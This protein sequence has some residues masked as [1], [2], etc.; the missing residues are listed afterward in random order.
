MAR[1]NNNNPFDESTID[2][3]TDT[4][5]LDQEKENLLWLIVVEM[6]GMASKK[7]YSDPRKAIEMMKECDKVDHCIGKPNLDTYLNLRNAVMLHIC[8]LMH[9]VTIPETGINGVQEQIKEK[10]NELIPN[11]K[12]LDDFKRNPSHIPDI[13]VKIDG[14]IRPIEVKAKKAV[15]ASVRQILRY[16]DF[17]KADKG[18]LIAPSL[19]DTIDLPEN[20]IFIPFDIKQNQN[21]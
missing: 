18:Y 8:Y 14:K 9:R 20:V 15:I 12:I 11:A 4:L 6:L 7:A 16:I 2:D 3:L 13:M 10:I 1:H 21:N 5:N 19:S 17:Y